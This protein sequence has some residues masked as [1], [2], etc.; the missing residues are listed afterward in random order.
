MAWNSGGMRT[1]GGGVDPVSIGATALGLL[2][3]GKGNK[4]AQNS[5][6]KADAAQQA[7]LERVMKLF[8]IQLGNV[9]TADKGGQFDPGKQIALADESLQRNEGN[10]RNNLA[11]TNRILGYRPGDSQPQVGDRKLSEG[12]DLQRRMQNFD[13]GQQTFANK[14][15]AYASVNPSGALNVA[16]MQ[17]GIA[18]NYRDQQQNPADLLGSF[19]KYYQQSKA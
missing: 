6:N 16:Q 14:M 1:G 5:A 9:Q 18:K 2:G 11:S 10:A 17:G 12:F 13:I 8:D 4:S 15:N 19:M 7:V 3:Q